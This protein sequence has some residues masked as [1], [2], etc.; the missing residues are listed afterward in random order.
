MTGLELVR[1]TDWA[2]DGWYYTFPTES[3]F[4]TGASERERQLREDA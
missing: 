1:T 3:D 2:M 4:E